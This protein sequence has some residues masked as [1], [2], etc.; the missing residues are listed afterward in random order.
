MVKRQEL[1]DR[2]A[3]LPSEDEIAA[4]CAEVQRGWTEGVRLARTPETLRPIPV[5]LDKPHIVCVDLGDV[6]E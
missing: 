1:S 2:S 4:R 3:Y 5:V 6:Q